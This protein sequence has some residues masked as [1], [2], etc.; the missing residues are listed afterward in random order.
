M[1]SCLGIGG[2]TRRGA[3]RTAAAKARMT[4]SNSD[5]SSPVPFAGGSENGDSD[6][7]SLSGKK[8]KSESSISATV[9]RIELTCQNLSWAVMVKRKHHPAR[10]FSKRQNHILL[11]VRPLIPHKEGA[12]SQHQHHRS[13][14]PWDQVLQ[15][16]VDHPRMQ[17]P[18]LLLYHPP[19]P[20]SPYPA[21][22]TV[23]EMG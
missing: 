20:S 15:D 12:D 4:T 8:G 18:H 17:H 23:R 5:R 10:I 3:A 6:N 13:E 19:I 2:S 1:A 11:P 21:V 22:R 14:A 9:A 7:E 16:S